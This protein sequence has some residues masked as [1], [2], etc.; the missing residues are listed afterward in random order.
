MLANVLRLPKRREA[1]AFHSWGNSEA[2]P[3]SRA[4]VKEP[5]SGL[6]P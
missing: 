6:D 1:H 3:Q 4:T 5:C 2:K